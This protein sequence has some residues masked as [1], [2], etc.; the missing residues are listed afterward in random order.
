MQL[1]PQKER[2]CIDNQFVHSSWSEIFNIMAQQIRT[3]T[4]EEWLKIVICLFYSPIYI[5]KIEIFFFKV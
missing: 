4:S 5:I 2:F 1:D 3:K